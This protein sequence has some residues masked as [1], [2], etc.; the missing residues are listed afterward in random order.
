V[1]WYQT[2]GF[3]PGPWDSDRRGQEPVGAERSLTGTLV[4]GM[5]RLE[6]G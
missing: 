1:E 2:H 3:A 6:A 4:R 5:L